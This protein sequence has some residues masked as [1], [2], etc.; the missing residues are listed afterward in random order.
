MV[1]RGEG[2][3]KEGLRCVR[4]HEEDGDTDEGSAAAGGSFQ[5][6]AV[7]PEVGK[8]IKEDPSVLQK[9]NG[10]YKFVITKDGEKK[11]WTVDAKNAPG[12]VSEG[13][14]G[15]ADCTITIDDEDY[16]ELITGKANGQQLFMSGKL[17]IAGNMALAMKLATLSAPK[18]S[19]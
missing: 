3:W 12:G 6:D 11:V 19:L 10:V 17:K 14:Q 13:E 4:W 8:R 9:I 15:K 7:F 1:Q 16:V 2:P 5:S 18:A